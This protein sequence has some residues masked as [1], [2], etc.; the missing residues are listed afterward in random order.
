MEEST[1]KG[2][3]TVFRSDIQSATNFRPAAVETDRQT[4]REA[5]R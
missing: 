4:N 2:I 1:G 5:D 3:G